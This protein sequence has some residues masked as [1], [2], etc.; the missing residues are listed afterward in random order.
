MILP[1]VYNYFFRVPW[2]VAVDQTPVAF[3]VTHIC[4]SFSPS[5]LRFLLHLTPG[6]LI[7]HSQVN[8]PYAHFHL[9]FC[10]EE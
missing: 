2:N 8:Y 9:G 1:Y 3:A 7:S 4:I 6:S 10:F 5:L